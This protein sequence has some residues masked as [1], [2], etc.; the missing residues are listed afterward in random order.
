[1]LLIYTPTITNRICYIFDLFFHNIL[2][3]DFEITD[4]ERKFLSYTGAKFSYSKQPLTDELFFEQKGTLLLEKTIRPQ[5]IGLEKTQQLPFDVFTTA[6]YLVSRYEE[7][8]P[9]EPDMHGRFKP[10]DSTAFRLGFLN[11]PIIDEYALAVRGKILEKYPDEK[12][13]E[14]RFKT[15]NTVDVDLAYKYRYRNVFVSIGGLM[16]D[17]LNGNLKEITER[18]KVVLKRLP[19]PFQTFEFIE[20]KSGGKPLIFFWQLGDRK[21]KYDKN[22]SHEISEFRDL[23]RHFADKSGIHLS[24][25]SHA[26]ADGFGEEIMRLKNIIATNVK[27]NRFHYL[28]MQLPNDYRTLINT[29]ITEDYTMGYSKHEGFRASIARPFYWYDLGKDEATNLLV[30]PF[31]FM[32][33]YFRDSDISADEIKTRIKDIISQTQ[34]VNGTLVALWHNNTFAE[35]RIDWKEIFEWFNKQTGA[36]D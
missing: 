4:D 9:H 19:D 2:N 29:G 15:I 14:K 35:T 36:N 6:F 32:D 5:E 31:M 11:K 16:R 17:V 22:A 24:Y 8:L 26:K 28:K 23:I 13:A 30:V 3:T 25:S 18:I 1:M 20:S 33:T 10:T 7:Y 27:R 12:I 21:G 34:K